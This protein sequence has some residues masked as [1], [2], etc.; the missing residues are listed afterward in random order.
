MHYYQFNIKEHA[1]ASYHLNNEEDLAFRRLK[2]MYHD[3]EKPIPLDTDSV[4]RRLRLETQWVL[5]V[6][7][8]FFFEAEDGWHIAEIDAEIALYRSNAVKNKANG[9]KGGRPKREKEPKGNPVGYESQ[10]NGNPKPLTINQQ[11]LTNNQD[12]H[13]AKPTRAGHVCRLLRGQC[14][15]QST[16]PTHPKLLEAIAAGATDDE[17]LEAGHDA[18][19]RGK[20]F[21]YAIGIVIG[22]LS[23]AKQVGN[24]SGAASPKNAPKHRKTESRKKWEE[25][26]ATRGAAGVSPSPF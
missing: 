3:T 1:L 24:G 25:D 18:V 26:C 9:A 19:A 14:K 6:L 17:F 21:G 10:P 20:S 22:R 12:T 11:P 2:D 7:K 13:I 4:A 5:N 15:M 16:S 23:D 8:D